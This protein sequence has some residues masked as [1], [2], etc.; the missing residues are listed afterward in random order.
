MQTAS[1]NT[2]N[3]YRDDD[4]R[5]DR[6]F[7]VDSFPK[8]TFQ[9]TGFAATD[10]TVDVSGILTI[11]GHSNPVMFS[12]GYAGSPRTP[13]VMRGLPSMPAPWWTGAITDQLE[14]DRGRQSHRRQRRGSHHRHRGGE[15]GLTSAG[16]LEGA[17]S[18]R[19]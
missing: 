13:R 18:V 4:L 19:G 12:G 6:F 16:A 7:A 3:S 9:G 8:M 15:G 17:P 14:R 2:G 10:S 1:L 5:S 11:K